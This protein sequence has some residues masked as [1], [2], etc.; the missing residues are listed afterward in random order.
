MKSS[1]RCG[2]EESITV[3]LFLC[4]N[5]I[6]VLDGSVVCST[7]YKLPSCSRICIAFPR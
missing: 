1:R 7:K 6:Y 5:I 2:P 3:L 4:I